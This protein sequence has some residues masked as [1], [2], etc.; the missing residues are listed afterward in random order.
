MKK[1]NFL[2]FIV[3]LFCNNSYSS[4]PNY[5]C[6]WMENISGKYEWLLADIIY[7]KSLSKEDCFDLDSCS[8]GKGLSDGGCYKWAKSSSDNPSAW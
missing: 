1:Y 8:G 3:V 4:Q 5:N 6:Y 2:F 7:N